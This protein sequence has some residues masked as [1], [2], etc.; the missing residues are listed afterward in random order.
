M[1]RTFS[2]DSKISA[3][4]ALLSPKDYID[5]STDTITLSAEATFEWIIDNNGSASVR[6]GSEVFVKGTYEHRNADGSKSSGEIGTKHDDGSFTEGAV[7]KLGASGDYALTGEVKTGGKTWSTAKG[8]GEPQG[9]DDSEQ[10]LIKTRGLITETDNDFS[11]TDNNDGTEGIISIRDGNLMILGNGA[12]ATEGSTLGSAAG[13]VI[14]EGGDFVYLNGSWIQGSEK[15]GFHFA[16]SSTPA[17]TLSDNFEE[18][19][20]LQASNM[21]NLDF[22]GTFYGNISYDAMSMFQTVLEGQGSYS[23]KAYKGVDFVNISDTEVQ[24]G[25]GITLSAG[26]EFNIS[27]QYIDAEGTMDEQRV[28]AFRANNDLTAT[29]NLPE[30]WK[31]SEGKTEFTVDFKRGDYISIATILD[32]AGVKSI[33]GKD[34]IWNGEKVESVTVEVGHFHDTYEPDP[35]S[36]YTYIEYCYLKL[37]DTGE[38]VHDSVND[39]DRKISALSG[40]YNE[41]EFYVLAGARVSIGN[42]SL[43]VT[44]ATVYTEDMNV[45]TIKNQGNNDPE[46][47]PGIGGNKDTG[48]LTSTFSGELYRNG[49]KD[50]IATGLFKGYS[51]AKISQV[52]SEATVYNEGSILYAKDG[53]IEG[54]GTIVDQPG[55][56]PAKV[57]VVLNEDGEQS[58]AAV[59]GAITFENSAGKQYRIDSAGNI[60]HIITANDIKYD[61]NKQAV[62]SV[63]GKYYVVNKSDARRYNG[64]GLFNRANDIEVTVERN[65]DD[66]RGVWFEISDLQEAVE[67]TDANGQGLGIYVGMKAGDM[68]DEGQTVGWS[69]DDDMVVIL[70]NGTKKVVDIDGTLFKAGLPDV[71]IGDLASGGNPD[72]GYYLESPN[73]SSL[74]VRDLAG[75]GGASS[76]DARQILLNGS[77]VYVNTSALGKEWKES[78]I[79]PETNMRVNVEHGTMQVQRSYQGYTY[80]ETVASVDITY[81]NESGDEFTFSGQAKKDNKYTLAG[82]NNYYVNFDLTGNNYTAEIVEQGAKREQ[83]VTRSYVDFTGNADGSG[84]KSIYTDFLIRN[85]EGKIVGQ[86]NIQTI[87]NGSD[88]HVATQIDVSWDK[89]GRQTYVNNATYTWEGAWKKDIGRAKDITIEP[90]SYRETYSYG[91]DGTKFVTSRVEYS[92]S[93]SD[94]KYDK[95]NIKEF[96]LIGNDNLTEVTTLYRNGEVVSVTKEVFSG[97]KGDEIEE[98]LGL[99]SNTPARISYQYIDGVQ[100]LQSVSGVRKETF[101]ANLNPQAA[102]YWVPSKVEFIKDFRQNTVSTT[103]SDESSTSYKTITTTTTAQ[104]IVSVYNYGQDQQFAVESILL[105]PE[106]RSTL[107]DNQNRVVYETKNGGIYQVKALTSLDDDK[108]LT[109][110]KHELSNGVEFDLSAFVGTGIKEGDILSVGKQDS[111]KSYTYHENGDVET[112]SVTYNYNY[113]DQSALYDADKYGENAAANGTV[114]IVLEHSIGQVMMETTTESYTYALDAGT[115]GEAGTA[116]DYKSRTINYGNELGHTYAYSLSVALGGYGFVEGESREKMLEKIEEF[117]DE[118]L[119]EKASEMTD[120]QLSAMMTS[121]SYTFYGLNVD[122]HSQQVTIDI[123]MATTTE[124]D[125]Y[126]RVSKRTTTGLYNEDGNSGENGGHYVYGLANS[127]FLDFTDVSSLKVNFN[128]SGVFS[129]KSVLDKA[130]NAL[131]DQSGSIVSAVEQDRKGGT[132]NILGAQLDFYVQKVDSNFVYDALGRAVANETT[133]AVYGKDEN[134]NT[135]I[136]YKQGLE[137]T[138]YTSTG[139]NGVTVA[140]TYSFNVQNGQIGYGEGKDFTSFET[141]GEGKDITYVLSLQDKAGNAFTPISTNG[142]GYSGI[143]YNGVMDFNL[144]AINQYNNTGDARDAQRLSRDQVKN[145]IITAV[146]TGLYIAATVALAVCTFGTSLIASITVALAVAAIPSVMK[147]MEAGTKALTIGDTSTAIKEFAFVA[148]DFVVVLGALGKAAG[149]GAKIANSIAKSAEAGSKLAQGVQKVMSAI[150]TAKQLLSPMS[151]LSQRSSALASIFADGSKLSNFF[152]KGAEILKYGIEG[153]RGLTVLAKAINSLGAIGLNIGLIGVDIAGTNVHF[154]GLLPWIARKAGFGD[155][156]DNSMFRAIRTIV[157]FSP[158]FN[159]EIW[160]SQNTSDVYFK[161]KNIT[162]ESFAELDGVVSSLNKDLAKLSKDQLGELMDK[163]GKEGGTNLSKLSES[164]STNLDAMIKQNTSAAWDKTKSVWEN[165]QDKWKG[166]SRWDSSKTFFQNIKEN[167]IFKDWAKSFSE[168]GKQIGVGKG[169][170]SGFSNMFANIAESSLT[171]SFRMIKDISK[172]NVVVINGIFGTINT[173][174]DSVGLSFNGEIP[175]PV[176]NLFGFIGAIKNTIVNGAKGN[177]W[178]FEF[179]LED[180]FLKVQAP[181]YSTGGDFIGASLESVASTVSSPSMWM[182]SATTPFISAVAGPIFQNIPGV[183]RIAN[184]ASSFDEVFQNMG[185]E[186]VGNMLGTFYSENIREEFMGAFVDILLPTVSP[187]FR[188]ML[189]ECFDSTPDGNFSMLEYNNGTYEQIGTNTAQNLAN[190]SQAQRAQEIARIQN[191]INSRA[192]ALDNGTRRTDFTSADVIANR[193]NYR[194]LMTSTDASTIRG[195][196]AAE[197][198]TSFQTN[199]S[200]AQKNQI[201][202]VVASDS[203]SDMRSVYLNNMRSSDSTVGLMATYLQDASSVVLTN[204]GETDSIRTDA[205][206]GLRNTQVTDYI[207]GLAQVQQNMPV[208]E[209]LTRNLNTAFG[210]LEGTYE[211]VNALGTALSLGI[212][213]HSVQPYINRMEFNNTGSFNARTFSSNLREV[214]RAITQNEGANSQALKDFAVKARSNEVI[215]TIIQNA[216]IKELNYSRFTMDQARDIVNREESSIAEL[217]FA[218]QIANAHNNDSLNQSILGKLDSLNLS[219]LSMAERMTLVETIGTLRDIGDI[220]ISSYANI[221]NLLGAN[222]SRIGIDNILKQYGQAKKDSR[223][224]VDEVYKATQERLTRIFG[225]GFVFNANSIVVTDNGVSILNGEERIDFSA[226]DLESMGLDFFAREGK[227]EHANENLYKTLQALKV[228]YNNRTG[229]QSNAE[230]GSVVMRDILSNLIGA[231]SFANYFTKYGEGNS[232]AYGEYLIGQKIALYQIYTKLE[233]GATQEDVVRYINKL[234]TGGGKTVITTI[235]AAM[236]LAR[237]KEAGDNKF[238]TV[239]TNTNTNAK[240]LQQEIKNTLGIKGIVPS[241]SNDNSASEI[242]D[243]VS[244]VITD[245]SAYNGA[246]ASDWSKIFE[247]AIG[248]QL[249]DLLATKNIEVTRAESG[250]LELKNPKESSMVLAIMR[251]DT[252]SKE[253]KALNLDSAQAAEVEKISEFILGMEGLS[254]PLARLGDVMCDEVDYF[255]TTPQQALAQAQGMYIS[256]RTLEMYQKRLE[257]IKYNRVKRSELEDYIRKMQSDFTDLGESSVLKDVKAVLRGKSIDNIVNGYRTDSGKIFTEYFSTM[258]GTIEDGKFVAKQFTVQIDGSPVTVS[259]QQISKWQ[260]ANNTSQSLGS[261]A[262]R[263]NVL[264]N[265]KN[266]AKEEE[267]AKIDGM[268]SRAS[269]KM[270]SVMRQT[271]EAVDKESRVI[272]ERETSPYTDKQIEEMIVQIATQMFRDYGSKTG[273]TAAQVFEHINNAISAYELAE[274]G[275]FKIINSLGQDYDAERDGA[276]GTICVIYGSQDSPDMTMPAG[277]MQALEVMNGLAVS[278]PSKDSYVSNSVTALNLFSNIIGVTGTVSDAARNKVFEGMMGFEVEGDTPNLYTYSTI[279]QTAKDRARYIYEMTKKFKDGGQAVFNLI[280]TA[281]S[282]QSYDTYRTILEKGFGRENITDKQLA[283]IIDVMQKASFDEGLREMV[284]AINKAKTADERNQLAQ[285]IID[286]KIS[287]LMEIGLSEAEATFAATVKYVGS[288]ATKVGEDG[289]SEVD[290][291]KAETKAG[292]YD[293]IMS[294]ATLIGRGWDA[295]DMVKAQDVINARQGKSG[296]VIANNFLLDSTMMT[297]SQLVQGAG[298]VDPYGDNRFS[299]ESYEK[300]VIEL[301]SVENLRKNA[302]LSDIVGT[303]GEWTIDIVNAHT[304]EIQ[305]ANEER[306]IEGAGINTRNVETATTKTTEQISETTEQTTDTVSAESIPMQRVADVFG[307]LTDPKH[308]ESFVVGDSAVA[309]VRTAARQYKDKVNAPEIATVKAEFFLT[310]AQLAKIADMNDNEIEK[311]LRYN[312]AAKE[313]A[314]VLNDNMRQSVRQYMVDS[315][316]DKAQAEQDYENLI[317]IIDGKTVTDVTGKEVTIADIKAKYNLGVAVPFAVEALAGFRDGQKEA[318]RDILQA[319]VENGGEVENKSAGYAQ[320]L[321]TAGGKSIIGLFSVLLLSANPNIEGRENKFITWLTNENSNAED[322]YNHIKFVFGSSLGNIELI[323]NTEDKEGLR[324]KLDN[325]GIIIGTYSS[326]GSLFSEAM[327]GLLS[328]GPEETRQEVIDQ[329]EHNK[330]LL[331][332]AGI[333]LDQTTLSDGKTVKVQFKN[334]KDSA[335]AIKILLAEGQGLDRIN[336]PIDKISQLV[337]DELDY[338]ATIPASA[339]A[340]AAGKYSRQYGMVDYYDKLLS[341][342]TIEVQDYAYLGVT[343][344]KLN[345]DREILGRKNGS[346][347]KQIQE[348]R[349][350]YKA[351]SNAVLEAYKGISDK[352]DKDAIITEVLESEAV[353]SAMLTLGLG[354]EQVK[355][356]VAEQ[357][358]SIRN[359]EV[360]SRLLGL[361]GYDKLD[362]T[363]DEQHIDMADMSRFSEGD[364]G[365]RKINTTDGEESIIKTVAAEDEQEGYKSDMIGNVKESVN[366]VMAKHA[367]EDVDAESTDQKPVITQSQYDKALKELIKIIYEEYGD[368]FRTETEVREFLVTGMDALSLYTAKEDGVGTGSYVVDVDEKG[369]PQNVYITNNGTPMKSLNMPGMWTIELMEGCENINKPSLETFISS[370]EALAAFEWS[371]GFSGTF[372]SSIRTL[373]KDLDYAEIGGSMPDTMKVGVTTALTQTQEEM[374][375]VIASARKKL[376]AQGTAG[377]DLIMTANSDGTTQMVEQLQKNGVKADDMVSLSLDLLDTELI[378]LSDT[379]KYPSAKVAA[380]MAANG[381]E[382]YSTEKLG[383]IDINVKIKVLQEVLKNVMKKGEVSFIVGDVSLLGRGW[384]PGDMGGA[385]DNLKAK[386]N[387]KG[388][389][390]V[391]ATM[392]KVNFEKMDATQSEQGDGRFAHRDGKS[393]FSSDFF[394]RDIVQITS[395]DSVREN[396][397]LREAAAKEG[398]YS[399]GMILDNLNDVMEANEESTLQKANN[400]VVNQTKQ[401]AKAQ[402]AKGNVAPTY[403]QAKAN[404]TAEIGEAAAEEV[405][406]KILEIARVREGKDGETMTREGWF[407]Y[408]NYERY[409]AASAAMGV[410]ANSDTGNEKVE[411]VM[412]GDVLAALEL[413]KESDSEISVDELISAVRN[414]NENYSIQ[415]GKVSAMYEGLSKEDKATLSSIQKEQGIFGKIIGSVKTLFSSD[416]RALMKE[417]KKLNKY[418]TDLNKAKDT[419]NG[420]ING[421]IGIVFDRKLGKVSFAVQ[422]GNKEEVKA[423]D[424]FDKVKGLSVEE[425]EI[426]TAVVQALT[427]P[428]VQSIEVQAIGGLLGKA[429]ANEISI[430]EIG[431]L[432]GIADVKGMSNNEIMNR[433][434]SR[435]MDIRKEGGNTAATELSVEL[436][437]IAG[438]LLFAMKA[439]GVDTV[440]A[441]DQKKISGNQKLISEILKSEYKDNFAKAGDDDFVINIAQLRKTITEEGKSYSAEQKNNILDILSMGNLKWQEE[442]NKIAGLFNMKNIHAIAASA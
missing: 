81:T 180:M 155:V 400:A 292:L 419:L 245:Y 93:I 270:G 54:L 134:G 285:K 80:Y 101:V 267:K 113:L 151:T 100:Y 32:K 35:D 230:E 88:S 229:S 300:H 399:V 228:Q 331:E 223:T 249:I 204:R 57:K 372:S 77:V 5:N 242:T 287:R 306:A 415:Q 425:K 45:T 417:S 381:V 94:V 209:Q 224:N 395:V 66:L 133:K 427:N 436:T 280:L 339:L 362:A 107:Y 90:G 322:L 309:A 222:G 41:Q 51:D 274:R 97:Y 233:G 405:M 234:Q 365:T 394:N 421:D 282:A 273:F 164:L 28:M 426:M 212:D 34:V 60:E 237:A 414:I 92:G 58:F 219:N 316:S 44:D 61:P 13:Y 305:M 79:D 393:R 359:L 49:D 139:A 262:E 412:K 261:V 272:E 266:G 257:N 69:S 40:E 128:A 160:M 184:F 326:W 366:E 189:K 166:S 150:N 248:Q 118:A 238:V 149:W 29:C 363:I 12:T 62:V 391:Q 332:G 197:M 343:E 377:V 387:I 213:Y 168:L 260:N 410:K 110:T 423:E 291:L 350:S 218:A 202:R 37:A 108:V 384:N 56:G 416:L 361:E 236:L 145:E 411:K 178:S 123:N 302:T 170:W 263:T 71:V 121:D 398:G 140:D 247:S 205:E 122:F 167:N 329:V 420:K 388:D 38:T 428:K 324:E 7:F 318:F 109:D 259:L 355:D 311:Y 235:A 303:N 17:K 112:N 125:E 131:A 19:Y 138:K 16:P 431:E 199:M 120:A 169:N 253:Y 177:G 268:V 208:N 144:S 294:D 68:K 73:L 173:A 135:V 283:E 211:M 154:D 75:K 442:E 390:K 293:Y 403:G 407:A 240:E 72:S 297:Q 3:S 141:V 373:L 64:E 308:A 397:I 48:D 47:N 137:V 25:D 33:T 186:E 304:Q 9:G 418:E 275:D 187:Q 162:G 136:V 323:T 424:I 408:E 55:N 59:A 15:S 116:E 327:A 98:S 111:V 307:R 265:A 67:L 215:N 380:V 288:S 172:F 254:I 243:S 23:S 375:T 409:V 341:G 342:A 227:D 371:V 198:A 353:Q 220:N 99:S 232:L 63:D 27:L 185:N 85:D 148:L 191:T 430:K 369:N 320:E 334:A 192:N 206:D 181:I 317:S 221:N 2:E 214:V 188:E 70:P 298:R 351:I 406:K 74:T 201:L 357:Y 352:K 277:Q 161:M 314:G 396:K 147:S 347:R 264:E 422:D 126:G 439:Q 83:K 330:K 89:L 276:D 389:A 340:S 24:I 251:N 163:V 336:L 295:G 289:K 87:L 8:D 335:A 241:F 117:G 158:I 379:K 392:W 153:S 20:K 183:G 171:N 325:A 315:A 76:E 299:S 31:D 349:D 310:D 194:V 106:T 435:M 354:T 119:L 159:K 156:V 96:S 432:F 345:K 250:K 18:T 6:D 102:N 368:V 207:R 258:N 328:Y 319:T 103:T 42:G 367:E 225:S 10:E 338:A 152:M 279:V 301:H 175:L 203:S 193:G 146:V 46:N 115:K 440:G 86:E 14:T 30:S 105:S 190:M 438:G 383:D 11:I 4:S 246:I 217:F 382:E 385:V 26:A 129:S 165:I 312:L 132:N 337:G 378:K 124:Y 348:L 95:N 114:E 402:D 216:N 278:K 78:Y 84:S 142:Y 441:L 179:G 244:L 210:R 252:S 333:K 50:L 43:T 413:I 360:R 313:V 271:S 239:L 21:D 269:G 130:G 104:D 195:V 374:A 255:A 284:P 176:P 437:A 39:V 1:S 91:P 22:T 404:L 127:D 196:I 157:A 286:E 82:Q 36:I 344:D 296:K 281:D 182:F 53:K 358:S 434:M 174:L 386:Q 376:N 65:G 321:Q 290:L 143:G 429:D 226:K 433:V 231:S 364:K 370:K 200:S 256:E 356:I 346:G 401:W 52:F